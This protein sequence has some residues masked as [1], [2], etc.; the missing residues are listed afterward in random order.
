MVYVELEP[1]FEAKDIIARIK[2]DAYFVNDETHVAVVDS[3]EPLMNMQH[4]VL[5]ERFGVSGTAHN[6][7]MAFHMTINNP[8]LTAQVMVA[9][10]RASL[11]LAPGCY[12]MIEIP[13]I[14]FLPGEPEE[15]IAHL[16]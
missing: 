14:A 12:T 6:Q 3:V 16:V 4:G 11:K 10:A 7:R 2:S 9:S 5:L 8:S 13:P 15:H 1:G